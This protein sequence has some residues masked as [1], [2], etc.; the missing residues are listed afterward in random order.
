[1]HHFAEPPAVVLDLGCGGGY[2]AIEAAKQWEVSNYIVS[3]SFLFQTV[4]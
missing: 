1:M 2:W 3:V 4:K